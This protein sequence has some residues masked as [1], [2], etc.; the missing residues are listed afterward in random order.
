MK[1]CIVALAATSAL[2][3]SAPVAHAVDNASW[4][5]VKEQAMTPDPAAKKLGKV[6]VCHQTGTG[7]YHLINI[8]AN[9]VDKHIANHGDSFPS[10]FY[11]DA[12]GDGFGDPS[13]ATVTCP[14]DGFVE[15]ADDC[16]DSDASVSPGDSFGGS[17]YAVVTGGAWTFGPAEEAC[18]SMFDGHLASIHSS[19]E[20]DFVSALVDPAATGGI[21]AWIGGYEPTGFTAGAGGVYTWS[22][23]SAWDYSNWRLTTGEPNGSGG[24]SPAGVQF[25]PNTNGFLS[26]WNDVPES[27]LFGTIVCKYQP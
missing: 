18:G 16:D 1:K 2:L 15:N 5:E 13:G 3:L 6:D 17:C 27:A 7:E 11:A 14:A 24:G 25:W 22:D 8:S 26:G 19:A 4:G 20:D 23:G 21:T 12:D 9:A 10:T